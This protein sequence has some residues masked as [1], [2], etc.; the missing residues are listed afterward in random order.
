MRVIIAFLAVDSPGNRGPCPCIKGCRQTNRH[1]GFELSKQTQQRDLRRLFSTILVL[2]RLSSYNTMSRKESAVKGNPTDDTGNPVRGQDDQVR[3]KMS[4]SQNSEAGREAGVPSTPAQQAS[5][6]GQGSGSGKRSKSS[7][8]RKQ[9]ETYSLTTRQRELAPKARKAKARKAKGVKTSGSE[10]T[11]SGLVPG[12]GKGRGAVRLFPDAVPKPESVQLPDSSESSDTDEESEEGTH[13]PSHSPRESKP[14]QSALSLVIPP[15][16]TSTPG[17]VTTVVTDTPVLVQ[18]PSPLPDNA[19]PCSSTP[20][21]QEGTTVEPVTVSVEVHE[22]P[23]SEQDEDSV[24]ESPLTALAHMTLGTQTGSEL[25]RQRDPSQPLS[26]E[27][28]GNPAWPLTLDPARPIA[29]LVG[30]VCAHLS[31]TRG[32]ASGGFGVPPL[33]AGDLA[34]LEGYAVQVGWG[35]LPLLQP[36]QVEFPGVKVLIQALQG[37]VIHLVQSEDD[38]SDTREMEAMDSSLP[39]DQS[40]FDPLR[41]TQGGPEREEGEWTGHPSS[42]EAMDQDEILGHDTYLD[43][44]SAS[45]AGMASRR[46]LLPSTRSLRDIPAG[47]WRARMHGTAV[48]ILTLR[49]AKGRTR[50]LSIVNC[51]PRYGPTQFLHRRDLITGGTTW[52]R[53]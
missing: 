11:K 22:V 6:S 2:F 35:D 37:T 42:P 21:K 17:D 28:T 27:V 48:T 3:D 41:L 53:T 49:G 25:P 26:R 51:T 8:T 52:W 33:S 50:W 36:K 4:A 15:Q 32:F 30:R 10:G 45:D 9:T 39:Q 47:P 12:A 40:E 23:D 1:I 34:M 31:P 7:R 20:V 43:W 29:E 16:G 19:R 13:P 46:T 38:E 14:D 24:S 5:V 44:G 18:D